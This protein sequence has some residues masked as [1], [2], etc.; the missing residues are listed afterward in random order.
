MLQIEW[1]VWR[2]E[3]DCDWRVQFS[4]TVIKPLVQ[5]GKGKHNRT[6][7]IHHKLRKVEPPTR[8]AFVS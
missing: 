1:F 7:S 6:E 2:K 4:C 5:E 8:G 3:N